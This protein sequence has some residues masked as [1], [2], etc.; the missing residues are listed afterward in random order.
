MDTDQWDESGRTTTG[1][2]QSLP[3]EFSASRGEQQAADVD[4]ST[5]DA[6]Q[7]ASDEDQSASDSDQRTADDDQR[8]SD[9]D[10]RTADR[11]RA[12]RP[13]SHDE[14]AFLAARDER[15]ASTSQRGQ[16]TSDREAA[17]RRR[18]ER[19]AL[20]DATA[21]TR[22]AAARARHRRLTE[23]A[24]RS[25]KASLMTELAALGAAAEADRARA[26]RDRARAATDRAR[27]ARDRSAASVQREKLEAELR[28]AHLDG[29][30]GSYRRELGLLTIGQ[31]IARA[32]RADGKFVLAFIDVDGLKALNDRDG[33]AAGDHAL[34]A[35]VGVL[36]AHLR[37]F[38][39]VIRYGGDEFLCTFAG[40]TLSDVLGRFRAIR[41]AVTT[42]AKVG[43]SVGLAELRDGDTA[44]SLIAR[45]DTAMLAEKAEHR[46]SIERRR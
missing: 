18:D 43:I 22:D 9:R 11:E 3:D 14:T 12:A 38:D 34:R 23:L 15:A 35:V 10:Q 27:A 2:G 1:V 45:A 25:T 41:A 32:R 8:R 26:A 13:R 4:Q 30:T 46:S 24:S 42:N 44:E 5:A 6:D 33:H 29:L 37:P 39:S 31:E 16:A 40:A 21:D 36:R 17:S 7:T 20:R 19:S 28:A